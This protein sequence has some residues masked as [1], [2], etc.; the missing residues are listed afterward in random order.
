MVVASPWREPGRFCGDGP[1]AGERLPHVRLGDGRSVHD[2]LGPGYTL[3]TRPHDGHGE[4]SRCCAR[5]G[6]P[7]TVAAVLDDDLAGR[8]AADV[9][10]VRPDQ[11]ISWSGAAL[12]PDPAAL[13]DRVCGTPGTGGA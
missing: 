8:Y 6:V 3:L 7:L 1:G 10:L 5:R 9:L 11:H 2:V 12:P 4:F 13:L